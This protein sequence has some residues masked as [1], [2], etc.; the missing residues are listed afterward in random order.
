[1]I[2]KEEILTTVEQPNFM[3]ARDRSLI[4]CS[5]INFNEDHLIVHKRAINKAA[6]TLLA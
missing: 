6:P 4:L 1:M 3:E 5:S 2:E